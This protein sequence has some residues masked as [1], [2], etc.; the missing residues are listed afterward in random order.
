MVLNSVGIEG[1]RVEIRLDNNPDKG[2]DV[3]LTMTNDG[4]ADAAFFSVD[5]NR[6]RNVAR[7]VVPPSEAPSAIR[8]RI[9]RLL[10]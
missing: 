9:K 8:R 6:K 2:V 5:R 1:F 10:A 3:L 7:E 4:Q